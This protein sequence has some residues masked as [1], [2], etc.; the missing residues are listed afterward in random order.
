MENTNHKTM[1]NKSGR[2]WAGLFIIVIGSIFLLDN[3]GLNVPH[4]VFSWSTILMAIGVFVGVRSNFKGST[5]LIILLIGTY[6]TL[7]DIFDNYDLSN[8]VFPLMLVGLGLYLVL[9]P[10][11][12]KVKNSPEVENQIYQFSGE[13]TDFTGE[14]K[15][16][17]AATGT[18]PSNDYIESVNVFGGSNQVIYTKNLKGGEVVA[19]FGGGDINLTQADFEG[20]IILDVTAV[21]GGIKIILPANWQT[22]SEVAAVF[23]GVDD[24]R[25]LYPPVEGQPKKILIIRGVVLFGGVEFKS[26]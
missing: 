15:Q 1:V 8:V 11:R 18:Y 16:Q 14:P 24:K 4:W 23:G 6:F 22:K 25:P 19:V 2:V 17:Q 7:S 26:Y 10:K 9:K 13:Q 21:F 20:Q 3:L 12:V 5:W